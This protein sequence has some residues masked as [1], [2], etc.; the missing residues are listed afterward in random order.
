MAGEGQPQSAPLVPPL[1]MHTQVGPYYHG[2]QPLRQE[3]VVV[4]SAVGAILAAVR[5]QVPVMVCAIAAVC[6]AQPAVVACEAVVPLVGQ[7]PECQGQHE[8][9]G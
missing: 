9:E 6:R 8:A 7:A 3:L 5:Q 4:R 1:E 2:G